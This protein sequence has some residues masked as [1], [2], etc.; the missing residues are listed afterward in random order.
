MFVLLGVS[1]SET[2]HIQNTTQAREVLLDYLRNY[3]LNHLLKL[4]IIFG[5]CFCVLIDEGESMFLLLLCSDF[6]SLN[7][8]IGSGE[9]I[10][11]L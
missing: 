10:L 4:P 7:I 1:H 5:L 2:Y 3:F 8:G 9:F 11:W 6:L